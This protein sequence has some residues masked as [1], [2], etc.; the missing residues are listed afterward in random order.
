MT[1]R[2]PS[3]TKDLIVMPSARASS[4]TS[5]NSSSGNSTVVL[6]EP[7]IPDDPYARS[8]VRAGRRISVTFPED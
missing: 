8:P 2:R 3:S 7:I 6:I 1:A 5:L 4:R